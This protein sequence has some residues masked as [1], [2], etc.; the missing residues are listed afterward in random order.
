MTDSFAALVLPIFREVNE[1]RAQLDQHKPP[2]DEVMQRMRALIEDADRRA[3]L[4]PELRRLF[5]LA[6]YGLVAWIDEV[7]TDS[8]WGRSVDWGSHEH[9]LEWFLY[10]SRDRYERFYEEA[11]AAR[12]V[13]STSTDPLEVYL[14]C[15]TQ[16]FRGR[17]QD[18]PDG[19]NDW[20]AATYDDVSRGSDLPARPFEST[21]AEPEGLRPLGGVRLLLTASALTAATAL[22]TL[23]GY[24]AAVHASYMAR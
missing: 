18:D 7:L 14:L 11:E 17:Y 21:D 22:V 10:R 3:A 4:D 6:R 12:E 13:H 8:S 2:L 23:A 5:E 15:V 24:L 1:L 16:G 19:F 20:V 9:V